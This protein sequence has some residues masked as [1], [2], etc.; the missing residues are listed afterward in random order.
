M[1]ERHHD[2][3][4]DGAHL[5]VGTQTLGVKCLVGGE[6]GDLDPQEIFDRSG[7]VVAFDNFRGQLHR[8]LE[9][10]LCRLCVLAQ[11]DG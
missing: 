10:L 2:V 5:R 1:G 4:R 6:V 9:R 7:H 8:A 3:G 11:S